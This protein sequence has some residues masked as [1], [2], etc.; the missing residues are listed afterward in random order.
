[1]T[2]EELCQKLDDPLFHR[3]FIEAVAG[4]N[5]CSAL[6]SIYEKICDEVYAERKTT[7]N[8][9]AILY[10]KQLQ[11]Q[12]YAK[13]EELRVEMTSTA[14]P[15]HNIQH[16]NAVTIRIRRLFANRHSEFA[17]AMYFLADVIGL[18]H[19]LHHCGGPV[20]Q[21][22]D[23]NISNEE[24]AML[25]LYKHFSFILGPTLITC[26]MNAVAATSFAQDRLGEPLFRGYGPYNVLDFVVSFADLSGSL[27][28]VGYEDDS[29][30]GCILE[31]LTIL[32]EMQPERA[33]ARF[34]ESG[35]ELWLY[36]SENQER[37]K[38]LGSV[39]W[40]VKEVLATSLAKLEKFSDE[41]TG[42]A[43]FRNRYNSLVE[44]ING[45]SD[46]HSLFANYDLEYQKI[47][48]RKK[49]QLNEACCSA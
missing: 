36:G 17:R 48:Q 35:F 39:L 44:S 5:K 8:V 6:V 23:E 28:K 34:P 4:K 20:R 38:Y 22:E 31:S 37:G 30:H 24:E 29:L 14:F 1:M 16:A 43:D 33:V 45:L 27:F 13:I 32:E 18:V 46:T 21:T 40:F 12:Y 9:F 19:D 25:Y 41:L 7:D 3:N 10:D 26:L 15:Y 49:S 42:V 2:A 47:I 11:Q